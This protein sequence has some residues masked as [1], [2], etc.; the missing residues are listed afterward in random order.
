MSESIKTGIIGYGLSGKV[1]HAPFIHQ[2]QGFELCKIVERNSLNSK[3]DYHYIEVVRDYKELLNDSSIELVVVATPNIYHFQMVKDALIAGKHVVVEKPFMTTSAEA[4]E[5]IKLADAKRRYLFVYQNRRWDGDFLTIK[6]IIRHK[7]LGDIRHFEAHFDR[8]SPERTRAAWRDEAIPGSGNLYDLGSHLIDQ[9]LVLFGKPHSLRADMQAQRKNSPV[10]DYFEVSMN[11]PGL[12]VILTAGM[13]VL[14]ND[15]RYVMQGSGG[16]FTKYGIDPQ[17]E[18]LKSGKMPKGDDWG[19]EDPGK[20]GNIAF[21]H[22]DLNFEGQVETE[23]GNYIAFY[24]NVFNV[25]RKGED[26]IIQVI[27]GRNVIKIIELA[28]ESHRQKKEIQVKF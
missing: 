17:E 22:A 2:H 12:Q 18:Q 1:F 26:S 23:A 19:K 21:H 24:E 13:L 10:D 8:Y 27:E 15:L 28:F 20:W 11:Y 5:I 3:S 7:L 4:D 14:E 16:T 25:I 9:A 6:K